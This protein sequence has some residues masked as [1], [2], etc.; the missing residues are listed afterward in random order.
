LII[1]AATLLSLR[2]W[3]ITLFT[4]LNAQGARFPLLAQIITHLADHC[5]TT[6]LLVILLAR[7]VRLLAAAL[8]SAVVIHL[9]VRVFK[10]YFEVLRP[11]FEPALAAG[12]FTAGPVLK[13]ESFSFPSGHSATASLIAAALVALWGRRAI[14]PAVVLALAVAAS[15]SMLGA[16]YPSDTAAGLAL[17]LCISLGFFYLTRHPATWPS[18]IKQR[19][20]YAITVWLLVGILV[21]S[22]L[23]APLPNYPQWFRWIAQAGCVA[24][25][26]ALLWQA[27]ACYIEPKNLS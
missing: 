20:G 18:A 26:G 1:I 16:H 10:Q 2:S 11:C 9:S 13:S 27:I 14:L 22:I 8:L 12:V 21:L 24:A 5:W 15:R 7:R 3:D 19:H 25:L 23:L 17:G 4:W 6:P